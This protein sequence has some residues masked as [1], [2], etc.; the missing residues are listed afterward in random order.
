MKATIDRIKNGPRNFLLIACLVASASCDRLSPEGEE[1]VR[2]LKGKVSEESVAPFQ[3]SEVASFPWNRACLLGPYARGLQTGGADATAIN[4]ILLERK[5]EGR[6]SHFV[7]VFV[8]GRDVQVFPI[9]RSES[10]DVS[11]AVTIESA[12]P[13]HKKNFRTSECVD[14]ATATIVVVRAFSDRHPHIIFGEKQ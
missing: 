6:E 9:R 3:L 1:F 5:F 13:E 11:G 14:R 10:A 12:A 2:R 7:F 4:S 8:N